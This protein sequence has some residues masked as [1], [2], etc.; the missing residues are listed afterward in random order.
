MKVQ[1]GEKEILFTLNALAIYDTHAH[2]NYS[3][4]LRII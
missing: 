1:K 3:H 2:V 4:M